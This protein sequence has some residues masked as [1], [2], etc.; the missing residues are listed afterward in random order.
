MASVISPRSGWPNRASVGR[1]FPGLSVRILDD[2]GAGLPAG[3]VGAIYI[4]S[5]SGLRFGY[6]NDP[7]KTDQAWR[8]DYFTVGDLGWLD[9][10][11]Y[12]F[13]ATA[14]PISSSAAG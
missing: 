1:P 11:G 4:S 8:D 10:E 14:G 9:E 2:E 13:L 7:D 12:L 3:E 6:H 5:F